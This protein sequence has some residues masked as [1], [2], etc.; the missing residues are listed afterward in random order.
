[1][2]N[3]ANLILSKVIHETNDSTKRI[4]WWRARCVDLDCRNQAIFEFE[5]FRDGIEMDFVSIE[6]IINQF[7][8]NERARVIHHQGHYFLVA[9]EADE[10][11][12]VIY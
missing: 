12:F 4:I 7:S 10:T 3:A 11:R 8:N 6:K 2:E 1:M 5:I 9:L